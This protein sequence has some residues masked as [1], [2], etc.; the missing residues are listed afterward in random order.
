M[1]MGLKVLLMV[2]FLWGFCC[3]FQNVN[4]ELELQFYKKSCPDAEKLVKEK[5]RKSMLN[6]LSTAA[7]ILRLAFHD[8]QV[9]GCDGSVLLENANGMTAETSSYRN[10]GIRKLNVI[11]EIKS[12]LEAI[13]P[14]TVSCADIIQ[15]AARE[16][17]YLTGGPYIKV[18]TGR[19]D[20]V[21]ASKERADKQLPAA[22]ISVDAFIQ[23]FRKKNISLEDGVALMGSHTLGIGHCRNFRERLWPT[24]DPTLSPP[25]SVMLQTICINPALSDVSFAQNDATI[26]SFDNQYFID[27]QTGRGLLKIDSEIAS[28]PRTQPYVSAFGHNTQH[29]FNRFTSGFLKLSNYK[30]LV[31]EEGEIRRDCRFRNS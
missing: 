6:D 15:L 30:V 28:D 3:L 13:C 29:F 17:V 10:F 7:A 4:G 21:S 9:D 23:I 20:T 1:A 11:N 25:F 14:E 2:V 12:S 5:M 8:C 19:R 22:Y 18:L 31:G 27:I 24:S 16:A 26:F